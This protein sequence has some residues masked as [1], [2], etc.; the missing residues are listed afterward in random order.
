MCPALFCNSY[1]I[2]IKIPN[3]IFSDLMSN[4]TIRFCLFVG[5]FHLR[6]H[7]Y[8]KVLPIA[9]GDAGLFLFNNRFY[10]CTS[11]WNADNASCTHRDYLIYK[12]WKAF[13]IS[14][15]NG[16]IK[17]RTIYNYRKYIVIN[18]TGISIT[19]IHILHDKVSYGNC[20][21]TIWQMSEHRGIDSSWLIS[22]IS[23]TEQKTTKMSSQRWWVPIPQS[24]AVI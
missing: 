1:Y 16:W 13:Y 21:N 24:H 14:F 15:V 9:N 12:Y 20:W 11:W 19:Y 10:L 5:L 2:G 6:L 17:I 23:N 8:W 18:C 3:K 4:R 22:L 7:S